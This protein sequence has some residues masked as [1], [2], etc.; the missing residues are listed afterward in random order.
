[1]KKKKKAGEMLSV[2]M[3]FLERKM[4][5][6]EIVGAYRKALEDALNT[7]K[8]MSRPLDVD[9]REQM[10]TV[11]RSTLGKNKQTKKKMKKFDPMEAQL[12]EFSC[13]PP[14][15]QLLNHF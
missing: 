15:P 13:P 11:V 5:P 12:F 14:P 1:M 8:S 10:L 4:H 9:D 2:A 6:T 3:P 7:M